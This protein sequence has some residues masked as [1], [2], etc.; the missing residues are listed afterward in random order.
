M[1]PASDRTTRSTASGF[2]ATAYVRLLF[3]YL[4][5][6]GLDPERVLGEPLPEPVDGVD[7][8]PLLRWQQLLE[9][10]QTHLRVPA[11]GLQVGSI[12]RPAHLGVLGYVTTHCANLGEAMQ[13]LERFERLIYEVNPAEI[14]LEC[15]QLVLAWSQERGRPGQLVDET[16]IAVLVT[17]ARQLVEGEITLR[18]VTFINPEP[19]DTRPYADFF[20]CPVRFAQAT[21]RVALPAQ[22]L[23]MPLRA[24]DPSLRA[25]LDQQAET[26][27]ARLPQEDA[28]EQ[29]LR[30][31]MMQAVTDG[32]PTLAQIALAL[33]RSP[34]TLQ[35]QLA[36]RQASFQE[37]LDDTRRRMAENYLRDERLTLT[38]IAHL[39]GYA[40]QSALNRAF[41]RWTGE[42]PRRFRK[43]LLDL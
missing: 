1:Q 17:F 7:R 16:A 24:P 20:G 26:L 33:H 5:Q 39:L 43:S 14:T 40:E 18:E 28:F 12:V 9:Q 23:T 25:L 19:A 34:R 37:Y 10:A 29:S 8:F 35:R 38:E 22:C 11:L 3:E 2:V 6:Q 41:K 31:A 4:A 42:T 21:T 27:L 15:D 13:R 30:R 36:E 32:E